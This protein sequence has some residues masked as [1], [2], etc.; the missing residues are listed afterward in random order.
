MYSELWLSLTALLRSYTALHGM[1]AKR[2][3]EIE[4]DGD[5][6]LAR[7]GNRRL[8]LTRK[9]AAISLRREDGRSEALELTEAGRLRGQSGEEEEMDMAAERWARELVNES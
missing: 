5:K 8:E 4:Q 3:A 6:I 7:C 1:S 9:G 2:Q